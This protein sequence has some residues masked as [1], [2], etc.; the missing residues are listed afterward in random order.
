MAGRQAGQQACGLRVS[1]ASSSWLAV[2]SAT[3]TWPTADWR[4]S[5]QARSVSS[6][7][8][9]PAATRATLASCAAT[10]SRS[11]PLNANSSG[12]GAP[13]T[14]HEPTGRVP[15]AAGWDGLPCGAVPACCG[16]AAWFGSRRSTTCTWLP[17]GSSE[18][19]AAS[20]VPGGHASADLGTR[21]SA[22]SSASTGCGR[23]H[24]VTGGRTPAFT[25]SAALISPAA[26]AA[27]LV[28]PML[29][30]TDPSTALALPRRPGSRSAQ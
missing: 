2:T 4:P 24:P 11:G 21:S 5:W 28:C 6:L 22:S 1:R 8:D 27:A 3:R 20:L 23:A 16:K 25:A 18:L 19:T 29:A 13:G 30:S 17:A 14:D 7:S 15:Q 9:N 10:A 12:R 26:P